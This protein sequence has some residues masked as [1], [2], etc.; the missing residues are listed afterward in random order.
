MFI[1]QFQGHFH[2]Q[3]L[4]FNPQPSTFYCQHSGDVV[5]FQGQQSNVC[6]PQE[7]GA[8][9]LVSGDLGILYGISPRKMSWLPYQAG[10]LWDVSLCRPR[11]MADTSSRCQAESTTKSGVRRG[12]SSAIQCSGD[13]PQVTSLHLNMFSFKQSYYSYL[14]CGIVEIKYDIE[15]L[16]L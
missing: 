9:D 15:Y 13:F 6:G 16:Y 2:F 8:R 7:P 10:N 3:A 14:L 12:P 5:H 4:M 1:I 11:R